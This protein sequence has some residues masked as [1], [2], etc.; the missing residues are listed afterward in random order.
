MRSSFTQ[1][2]AAAALASVS[3]KAAGEEPHL[4]SYVNE[5]YGYAVRYPVSLLQPVTKS[6]EGQSFASRSGHAGFRVFAKDRAKG[7]PSDLADDVQH[8]CPKG[9]ASYRVA[10]PMLVA[11]SC[12]VGDH[13]IYQKTMLR[14]GLEISVRGEYPVDERA[15]WDPVVTTI[16]RS[17]SVTH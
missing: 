2:L 3:S 9:M 10:K 11:V 6:S 14:D 15:T 16:A 8:V 12:R 5:S 17:M 4:A 7:S 1:I 13:I